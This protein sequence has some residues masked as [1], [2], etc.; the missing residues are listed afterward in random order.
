MDA[1]VEADAVDFESFVRLMRCNSNDSLQS[2]GSSE[3]S[4][5]LY[6]PRI[7]DPSVHGPGHGEGLHAY[8]PALET[9]PDSDAADD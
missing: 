3:L 4:Y 1:A 9:V 2:M 5:D 7:K 8:H 6:D